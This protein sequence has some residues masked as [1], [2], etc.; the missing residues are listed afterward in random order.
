MAEGVG[1]DYLEYSTVSA[2]VLYP[3]FLL[4]PGWSLPSPSKIIPL[5]Q[6]CPSLAFFSASCHGSKTSHDLSSLKLLKSFWFHMFTW[7]YPSEEDAWSREFALVLE[8]QATAAQR[9]GEGPPATR[10]NPHALKSQPC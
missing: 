3:T 4:C 1:R 6:N 5:H 2:S 9:V 8:F 10:T 7:I